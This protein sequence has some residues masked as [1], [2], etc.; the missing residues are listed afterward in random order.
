[1]ADYENL[2]QVRIMTSEENAVFARSDGDRW[3]VD[4]DTLVFVDLGVNVDGTCYCDLLLSQQ[5]LPATRQCLN[6]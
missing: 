3:G 4:S 6:V 5:L 1:M 2:L